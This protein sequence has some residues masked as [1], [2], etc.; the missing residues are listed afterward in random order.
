MKIGTQPDVRHN[1]REAFEFVV[2]ND[3]NHI[4]LLMDHPFFCLESIN[5]DELIELVW[6][7]DVELLLHAP[8]T[9][10]NFIS[11]SETM[12]R[13]S[14]EEMEKVLRLADKCCA[15]V[16][17]FHIG[18]NPS[19]VNNGSFYFDRETFEK[20]NARVLREELKPFLQHSP[21][22]LAL[23]NTIP[24][25]GEFKAA[26]KEILDETNLALTL[27]IGHYN[28]SR[29][30]FFIENFERVVN[31]HVHDNNG[32]RDEHIALGKGI[33]DLKK[34]PLEKFDGYLTIETR[35][36]NSILETRDYLIR[37]LNELYD[38]QRNRV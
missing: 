38:R 6:S 25:E 32:K 12:R 15:R 34:F 18:W 27:D 33:V 28:V 31:I 20:H 11:I 19:F 3:F 29:C 22:T 2:D 21:V 14:Y 30:D 37:Y 10:T 35:E 8:A 23:E 4:E 36:V 26:L 17:T 9:S 13:A 5:H 16:V 24:I 1:L 7:Y